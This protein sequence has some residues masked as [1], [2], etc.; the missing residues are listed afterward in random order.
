M[1]TQDL[2]FN[3]VPTNWALCFNNECKLRSHCLRHMAG[4]ALPDD[5]MAAFVVTPRAG[6]DGE[7]KMFHK[8]NKVTVAVGFR[9]LFNKVRHEDYH[10]MVAELMKY[11]GGKTAYYR[12]FNGTYRLRPEQQEWIHQLFGRYGYT[13]LVEFNDFKEEYQ[14]FE[15]GNH[16]SFKA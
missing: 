2:Q 14:F 4:D 1:R 13:G 7:C 5:E 12:Y 16:G 3:D 6:I 9:G 15:S 10:E 8:I 11:L